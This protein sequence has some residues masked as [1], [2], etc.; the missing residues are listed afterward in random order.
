MRLFT[1]SKLSGSNVLL[2]SICLVVIISILLMNVL[3]TRNLTALRSS[4]DTLAKPNA[5]IQNLHSTNEELL[6]A[7]NKFRMYLSTGDSVYKD[8]FLKHINRSV[9]NLQSVQHSEDSLEIAQILAGLGKKIE[10]ADAISKLK[11]L[12]DSVSTKLNK[13]KIQPILNEPIKVKKINTSILKKYYVHTTDTVKAVAQKKGFFK[14]LGAL[15]TNK[16]N[17]NYTYIKTDSTTS[18][19]A[20]DSTKTAMEIEL[21]N[22][23]NDIQRFYQG[24]LN[25]ELDLRRQLNSNERNLAETN[26]SIIDQLNNALK[27]VLQREEQ[28]EQSSNNIAILNAVNARDS[29]QNLSWVSFAIIMVIIVILIFNIR[30][31]VQY[32]KDIL[33][34][35]E[36]AEKLA[37]TKTRFLN[38]MSHEIRSPLTSIIGFTEQL[39]NNEF[40]EEKKKFLSAIR[41]SSD[42]LLNTV[43]DVLDYSK[44]DAGKLMLENVSFNIYNTIE[45]VIYSFSV[46]ADKKQIQLNSN[47]QIDKKVM[48]QGDEFRLRQILFNL[49]GNAIKFTSKGSVTVTA[50]ALWK[51]DT[52]LVLKVEILDSGVGIPHDQLGL[53]FE[54][55]A[56]ASN[57]KIDGRRAI[58]GTGLGLPI[59]KMLVEMQGG[60]INVQSEINKGSLFTVNLPYKV[61]VAEDHKPNTPVESTTAS[62]KEP[63]FFFGKKALV[64][65]DNDMNIMLLSLLLKKYFIEFDVAKDGEA[66]LELFNSK[67]Y[68]IVLTDINV[69]KL[70]GDQLTAAIRRSDDPHK[71]NLPIIALTAS[72]V[73]DDLDSYLKIGIN[74]IMI[75]PFKE[76]DFSA[77]LKKYLD[78]KI[79][80]T[81]A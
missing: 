42:H 30:R 47:I 67:T 6:I 12:S 71:A 77:M 43:N 25:K 56:Q 39:E 81:L 68:D 1:K 55:F 59:C 75:K 4:I 40:D 26:L 8:D 19:S 32:E 18:V 54:E 7:E 2:L 5:T 35:R 14:K 66:G 21:N 45:E 36:K 48:V 22:L 11:Y 28:Q 51:N 16:D 64:V 20:D 50:S 17:T 57:N 15:F 60:N 29:I 34:A 49:T 38:N 3:N 41:S 53:I 31:T 37:L 61:S 65:E 73:A 62:P 78:N 76:A 9:T 24:S 80:A 46:H 13:V 74:D 58:R 69:P 72:I 44:L 79:G 27:I 33:E 52:D 70:T 63:A 23:S 10:L